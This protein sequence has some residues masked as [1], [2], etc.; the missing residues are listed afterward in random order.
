[1][2]GSQCK[3]TV[4]SFRK[5]PPWILGPI[6]AALQ[7]V[8]CKQ[9][10]EMDFCMKA[11]PNLCRSPGRKGR[12][13]G[14]TEGKQDNVETSICLAAWDPDC[15]F[16]PNPLPR[17]GLWSAQFQQYLGSHTLA[18]IQA[19]QKYNH[20]QGEARISRGE[21]WR[22]LPSSQSRW[23]CETWKSSWKC[24]RIKKWGNIKQYSC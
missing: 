23:I 14:K 16:L 21:K 18:T 24:I 20:R 8:Y 7:V 11:R 19:A 3:L 1:M 13:A 4:I 9:K 2:K 17:R 5:Y 15:C 6:T 12:Q 22:T 10:P